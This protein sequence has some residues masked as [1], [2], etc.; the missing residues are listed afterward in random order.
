MRALDKDKGNMVAC[1][2]DRCEDLGLNFGS[3]QVKCRA[4]CP[5]YI[6]PVVFLLILYG[7]FLSLLY[8][9]KPRFVRKPDSDFT[10]ADSVD[11]VYA[12]LYALLFTAIVLVA[13]FVVVRCRRC[14]PC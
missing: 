9:M 13:V 8:A 1:V 5:N 10:K 3:S 4:A 11:L 7:F 14:T 12:L 6:G 2:S